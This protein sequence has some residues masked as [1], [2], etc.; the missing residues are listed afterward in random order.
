MRKINKGKPFQ[1]FQDFLK[2]NTCCDYADFSDKV[3]TTHLP[4]RLRGYILNQEQQGF[5]A[6]TEQRVDLD[7]CHIDHFY[8]QSLF[9]EKSLD[10]D[11][12][13]VAEKDNPN[14]G[15]DHKDNRIKQKGDYAKLINPSIDDPHDYFRYLT[16]GEICVRSGL[17]SAEQEKASYT[18]EVF[19]LN[20]SKLVNLRKTVF[21]YLLDYKRSLSAC[22]TRLCL[23]GESFPSLIEYFTQNKRWAAL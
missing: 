1:D 2:Q 13:L 9:S 7:R 5:C 11:N 14:F 22:D 21:G 6:Y 17:S 3:K 8:K 23:V 16:N 12:F 10:W 15:A 4:Q 20:H 19:N 18:I